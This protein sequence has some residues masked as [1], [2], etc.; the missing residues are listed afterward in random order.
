[1]NCELIQIVLYLTFSLLVLVGLFGG[2]HILAIAVAHI[3]HKHGF[4]GAVT[5]IILWPWLVV[6]VLC[7]WKEQ[8]MNRRV[9]VLTAAALT[10]AILCFEVAERLCD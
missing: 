9:A 2:L 1:M 5:R 7:N 8:W 3:F 4:A 6:F 10:V